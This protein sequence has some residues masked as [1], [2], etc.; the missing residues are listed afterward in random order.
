MKTHHSTAPTTAAS[1]TAIARPTTLRRV[2]SLLGALFLA[3]VL[4]WSWTGTTSSAFAVV[5]PAIL[6]CNGV[7]NAAGG[8]G[9]DCDVVVENTLD[10]ST[11]IGSSVVT[12]TD[13]HGAA[14]AIVPCASVTTEFNQVITSVNQC[15]GS[16]NAGGGTVDCS[17]S[18]INNITGNSTTTAATVNQC[19]E[20]GEGGADATSRLCSPIQSTTN[21]TVTQCN[22]SVNGGGDA[23]RVRCTVATASTVSSALPVTV[24]QCNGSANGGGAVATCSVS[25]LNVVDSVVVVVPTPTPSTPTDTP[26][27]VP[28]DTPTDTPSTPTDTPSTPTS[29]TDTPST[30]P[31]TPGGGGGNGEGTPPTPEVPVT[32]GTPGTPGTP[33]TPGGPGTPSTPGTPPGELAET[34]TSDAGALLLGAMSL[35]FAGALTVLVVNVQRRRRSLLNDHT[36]V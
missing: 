32:P 27:D 31:T 10:V 15:N 33:S 13:C 2:I 34:G 23:G 17:V 18:I 4:I 20:A 36:R 22:G 14:R 6:Q 30:P 9:Q 29:P 35:L 25:I 8:L 12:V 7:D 26:S 11:G 3:V 24:N 5:A 21:A 19:I 28:T 16:V 1:I